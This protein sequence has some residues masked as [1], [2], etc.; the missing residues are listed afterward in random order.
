MMTLYVKNDAFHIFKII[1]FCELVS[2]VW[3]ADYSSVLYSEFVFS[4]SFI[5]FFSYALLI[6][7]SFFSFFGVTIF[8]SS[9]YLFF[10]S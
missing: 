6:L 8:S 2:D 3:R 10:Y 5:S 9:F 7:L 4:S 1:D